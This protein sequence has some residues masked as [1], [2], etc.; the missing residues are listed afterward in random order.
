[1]A[2][3][4]RQPVQLSLLAA[5]DFLNSVATIEK[6]ERK[7]PNRVELALTVELSPQSG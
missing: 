2:S 4:E 3:Q 6:A 1:M 5:L 7:G